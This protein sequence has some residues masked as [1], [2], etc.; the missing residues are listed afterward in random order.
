[1]TDTAAYRPGSADLLRTVADFL[2]QIGPT[3]NPGDRYSALVCGHILAM[4]ERE[5]THPRLPP[6]DEAALVAAIRNG[7]YDD[8]VAWAGLAETILQRTVARVR[9]VKPEHLVQK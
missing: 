2:T 9:V 4:L 1:M 6:L 3:L 7:H 5:L 8:D